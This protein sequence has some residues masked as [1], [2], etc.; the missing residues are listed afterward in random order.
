MRRH[1]SRR[2]GGGFS[3][4]EALIAAAILLL[5]AIGVL[6]LFVR[7]MTSNV[8]GSESTRVSNYGKAQVEELMQLPFGSAA[9]SITAGSRVDLPPQYWEDPNLTID[10]DERWVTTI[11][12]GRRVLWQRTATVRQYAIGSLDDGVLQTSEALDAAT[13]TEFVHFKEIEVNVDPVTYSG[14]SVVA[15]TGS[16]LSQS[17]RLTARALKS[18]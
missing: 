12:A 17:P 3:I 14:G 7:S 15:R 8:T 4:V 16:V 10:G 1:P 6:P 13:A 18:Q 11:T 2:R 9:I 5:V